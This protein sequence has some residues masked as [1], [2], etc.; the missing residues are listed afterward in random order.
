MK[1]LVTGEKGNVT[2]IFKKGRKNN[3]G[4]YQPVSLTTVPGK[5]KEHIFLEA[6]L[7]HLEEKEVIRSKQCGF[8]RGKSS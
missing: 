2:L 6:V 7:R 4:N 1:S 8:I 5:V 3:P